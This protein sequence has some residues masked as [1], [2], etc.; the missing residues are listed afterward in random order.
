MI[1]AGALPDWTK[2]S[3]SGGNGACVEVRST[4]ATSVEVTDSKFRASRS[5]APV[6]KVSPV[7]FSAMV[8]HVRV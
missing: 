6:F 7:A 2:S 5:G 3:H 8:A 1:K 4:E